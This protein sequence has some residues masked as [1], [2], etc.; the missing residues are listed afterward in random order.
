MKD[1]KITPP[2]GYEVD[3][4]KSTFEHI[5]YKK[6]SKEITSVEDACKYLGE[7][8]SDVRELRLLQNV[9]NLSRKILAGQ[10]LTVIT[11]ALN[12]DWSADFD[13]SNQYKY[14]LW[15]YLGSNFRLDCVYDC[16]S[17]SSIPARLCYKSEKIANYSA[18][19]FKEVWK[20][21]MN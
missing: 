10:E 13:N 4:D 8:D 20:E 2:E 12:G 16:H 7:I 5:I 18:N 11:K 9:P 21:F 17:D 1:L 15:W 6:V 19:T 3:K 14:I